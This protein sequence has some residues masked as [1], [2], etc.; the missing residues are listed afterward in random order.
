MIKEAK[1]YE[2]R[3][4]EYED[5]LYNHISNV[6]KSFELCDKELLKEL[7][8]LDDIDLEEIEEQISHHDESKYEPEEWDA[9]LDWF[10]PENENAEK[11]E[12]GYDCAWIHHYHNNPHHFQY[13]LCFDDDGT[14]R[15]I[16]MPL[17]YI[18]EALCD[19][20]SFSAKNSDSTAKSWW[21][22]HKDIFNMTE[23]TKE[24]FDKLSDLFTVG[25]NEM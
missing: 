11:D 10:Y 16:D 22:S 5:Y 15:P 12:Y 14:V 20:H 21:E 2:D 7:T 4:S 3:C 17:N 23:D 6:Q 1:S 24:W 18:I 19:W 9:Y 8:G 25:V 13:W